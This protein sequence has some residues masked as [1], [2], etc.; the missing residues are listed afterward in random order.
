MAGEVKKATAKVMGSPV[1][2]RMVINGREVDYF[3]GTSY[4]ALHGHPRVMEAAQDAIAGYGLG[5]ATNASVPPVE[6]VKELAKT[7]FGTATATYVIS[8]YLGAM[9]LAQALS[10]EYDT[11]FVDEKSHFSVFD[12]VA[13]V[14]K[15]V[16]GFGHLDAGDLE[17]KLRTHL[18]P[19]MVPLVMTDGVFPV[20]GAIAPL[21]EYV[22]ALRGHPNALLCT[23]DSH[24]VGVI[25]ELGRG[26][27]EYFGLSGNRFHMAGTLSKAC[28][29]IGGIIP[30]DQEL[31][32][33]IAT[34]VRIPI[35]A[36]PPPVPA[37]AAAAAGLQL[38]M[39]HPEMREALWANVAT[40][41]QGFRG[42]GFDIA[43]SPIPIVNVTGRPGMDLKHVEEELLRNDVAVLYVPP[44]GYSDAPDVESLR[45]AV[46]STHTPEQIEKLVETCRGVL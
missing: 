23:D 43:D 11:V 16:V 13:S 5:P 6:R 32:D 46:F 37:A 33:R 24:A 22:E 8:G 38:L 3:C 27:F 12:G 36:S 40:V 7:F 29:G 19:G 30:G 9:I 20:T 17:S 14:G 25:G 18:R 2:A 45:I 44:R 28:G 4:F 31:A 42:L 39:D 21:P 10:P 15:R 1:G 41:R 26:T 34:S 35:G